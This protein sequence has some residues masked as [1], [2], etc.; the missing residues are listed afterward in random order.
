MCVVATL[1][2]SG[3]GENDAEEFEE[4]SGRNFSNF[5]HNFVF[6]C[7][8]GLCMRMCEQPNNN[9]RERKKNV[10][11]KRKIMFNGL[12]NFIMIVKVE[13]YFLFC[14]ILYIKFIYHETNEGLKG[15]E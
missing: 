12:V 13:K 11:K 14:K 10:R 4:I 3:F 15:K 9:Q 5:I 1:F 7:V 8:C 6:V 2:V